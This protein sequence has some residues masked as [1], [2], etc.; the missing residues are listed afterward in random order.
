MNTPPE[1]TVIVSTSYAFRAQ[2]GMVTLRV[3]NEEV[4]MLPEKARSLA[5]ELL[6]MAEE[7][8]TE[9]LFV[10]FIMLR[11]NMKEE[12]A[13]VTLQE[14]RRHRDSFRKETL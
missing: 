2:T 7:A 10:D 13:R 11:L 5:A 14:F 6:R 3:N 12:P 9:A 8:E 1:H 4:E